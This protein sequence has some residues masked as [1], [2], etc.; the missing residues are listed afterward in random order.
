MTAAQAPKENA[1]VSKDKIDV[2]TLEIDQ[3][4]ID[5]ITGL[6]KTLKENPKKEDK[7]KALEDILSSY[8]SKNYILENVGGKYQLRGRVLPASATQEEKDKVNKT[9]TLV[10][11]LLR[12]AQTEPYTIE[13]GADKKTRQYT[14]SDVF[15]DVFTK[16]L[17]NNSMVN[18]MLADS[19]FEKKGPNIGDRINTLF[20][21]NPVDDKPITIEEVN[22]RA[23]NHTLGGSLETLINETRNVKGKVLEA[24]TAALTQIVSAMHDYKKTTNTGNNDMMKFAGDIVG[25]MYPALGEAAK[26]AGDGLNYM[27]HNLGDKGLL[28]MV[29]SVPKIGSLFGFLFAS[30][31]PLPDT[32]KTA[33]KIWTGGTFLFQNVSMNGDPIKMAFGK[34]GSGMDAWMKQLGLVSPAEAAENNTS[35]APAAAPNT[36]PATAALTPEQQRQQANYAK[37][38]DSLYLKGMSPSDIMVLKNSINAPIENVLSEV[39]LVPMQNGNYDFDI[40]INDLTQKDSKLL[41]KIG[42]DALKTGKV[43]AKQIQDGFYDNLA[44]VG[45]TWRHTLARTMGEEFTGKRTDAYLGWFLMKNKVFTAPS[46][47]AVLSTAKD[48]VNPRTNF[49]MATYLMLDRSSG[50]DIGDTDL[51]NK[52]NISREQVGLLIANQKTLKEDFKTFEANPTVTAIPTVAP[53]IAATGGTEA[54]AK[55]ATSQDTQAPQTDLQREGSERMDKKARIEALKAQGYYTEDEIRALGNGKVSFLGAGGAIAENAVQAK[56]TE[57]INYIQTGK[58]SAALEAI[59]AAD[60]KADQFNV[61]RGRAIRTLFIRLYESQQ[62]VSYENRIEELRANFSGM[63]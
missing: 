33:L 23:A 3:K 22:Q 49:A 8:F 51:A 45:H 17:T 44:L 12:N 56:V 35:A 63:A 34:V 37:A 57:I 2:S 62:L 25:G 39:T 41:D 9:A 28:G 6:A 10:S 21:A 30:F 29:D 40:A 16:V 46:E 27:F 26:G 7:E 31:L 4:E 13:L 43:T 54:P 15:M 50:R 36:A 53:A 38:I 47:N 1:P 11:T 5:R 42:K 14:M 52:L 32:M 24:R 60:S 59:K 20:G 48:F 18:T 55:V 19:D 61:D 58:I